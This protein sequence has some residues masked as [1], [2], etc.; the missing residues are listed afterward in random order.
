[1]QGPEHHPPY[2][3]SGSLLLRG[4]LPVLRK[5]VKSQVGRDWEAVSSHMITVEVIGGKDPESQ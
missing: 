5:V 4:L 1:M 2:A 3:A